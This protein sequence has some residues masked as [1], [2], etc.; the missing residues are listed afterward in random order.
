MSTQSPAARHRARVLGQRAASSGEPGSVTTGSAYEL[1]LMQLHED[2]RTLSAIQ[3]VERKIEMKA[4][5]LPAYQAWIDGVLTGGRGA[6]DEVLVTLLVWHI[7]VGEIERGLQIAAY[8][9]RYRFTLPDRY[10]RTLPTLLQ[11]EV[12]AACLTGKLRD[13]PERALALLQ[14]VLEMTADDDTPDQARA[15]VHK[16]AGLAQLELVNRVEP[17]AISVATA[18]QARAALQHLTRATALHAGAGV[19]K[20]IERLERRLAKPAPPQ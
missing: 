18:E 19:K 13:Q 2:R 15:K 16:A 20:D 6:Y 4:T 12:A 9:L 1:M 7:D 11:D 17:E 3:S 10:Q 14:Q 8:A 5:L